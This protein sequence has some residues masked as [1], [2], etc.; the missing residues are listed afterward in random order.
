LRDLTSVTPRPSTINHLEVLDAPVLL[1]VAQLMP[2][3]RP[4]F[5]VKAMHIAETYLGIR[6]LLLLVGPHR[7]A[8]YTNAIR[9]QIRELH[10]LV[11]VVGSVDEPDLA[12]MFR[13]ASMVLT[14]S[15]HEGFCLP[16]VEAMSFGTPIVARAAAA[17]PETV[18]DAALLVPADHGPT[19]FAEA[20]AELMEN[21]TLRA[22]LTENGRAR[23]AELEAMRPDAVILD[24]LL[25]VV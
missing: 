21:D 1:C 20:I 6:N 16:L 22:T 3:K 12:A 14:A 15:E 23:Y 10:V 5:L 19:L 9:A 13:T 24:T 11:H 25:A 4:D 2:H 8:S 7:L 17:V 18:G